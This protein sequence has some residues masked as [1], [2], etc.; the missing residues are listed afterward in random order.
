LRA[1]KTSPQSD[2]EEGVGERRRGRRNIGQ[3]AFSERG[4]KGF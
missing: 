4:S 2:V 3:L 1:D